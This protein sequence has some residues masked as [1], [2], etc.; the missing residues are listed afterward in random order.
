MRYRK[1]IKQSKTS[2]QKKRKKKR[3]CIP[4]PA[5]LKQE[6]EKAFLL[7]QD[8][9]THLDLTRDT[10]VPETNPEL[11]GNRILSQKRC[12]DKYLSAKQNDISMLLN[13]FEY[14]QKK[15]KKK[16]R[17][18]LAEKRSGNIRHSSKELLKKI[19][20]E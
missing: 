11:Q 20:K 10:C 19:N 16:N 1:C 7:R 6:K 12:S 9:L 8:H 18:H 5:G 4:V 2:D 15:T 17:I 14:S 13:I 3:K